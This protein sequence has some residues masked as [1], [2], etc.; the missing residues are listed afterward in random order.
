M[1]VFSEGPGQKLT[2]AVQPGGD[3]QPSSGGSEP[4]QDATMKAADSIVEY[5]TGGRHLSFEE[6]QKGGPIVHY[7]F[8]ALMGGLYGGLAEYSPLV[9]SGF[10]TTFGSVLFGGANLLAVPALNLS[11][12]P[13]DA[14]A[15]TLVTPYA[16]HLVYGITTELV[17]RTVRLI[18]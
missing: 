2:Q 10:G 16:T 6:Q 12:S 9:R 4:K 15:A 17:R 14:P 13:K 1:N 11:G 5:A 18:L 8:G 7:A 3:E